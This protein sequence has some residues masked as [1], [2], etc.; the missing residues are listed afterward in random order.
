VATPSPTR[1]HAPERRPPSGGRR[2]QIRVLIDAVQQLS[3]ARTVPEVQAIVRSAARRLTGADGATFVLRQGDRCYYADE[4]AIAPLWKGQRFPLGTCISGWVMLN[5]EPAAI[6]NIYSDDRIPHEAYRPTFVKSLLMVPMRTVDPIGAIGNYWASAHRPTPDEI[7]LLQA[8]ADS[9][10]V[11]MENV[12]VYQELEQRVRDRTAELDQRR[13]EL[14]AANE[15]LVQLDAVRTRF[16][17]ATAHELRSPLT[18]VMGFASV[19]STRLAE[20]EA[21]FAGAIYQAATRLSALVDDLLKVAELEHEELQLQRERVLVSELIG[22]S[23]RAFSVAATEA[24]ITLSSALEEGLAIDVDPLRLAQLLDN[25]ISNAIKYT[26]A[27][28]NVEVRAAAKGEHVAIEVV[29]DGIGIDDVDKPRLFDAFF[30]ALSGREKAG[31]TGLGLRISREIARAHG[32]TLEVA[33]TP[34]GG[35]TFRLLLPR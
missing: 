17:H 4:D 1:T 12:R 8:L 7:E 14:E 20:P 2:E 29:D 34:G 31:G 35:S 5:R 6:E 19:L 9:T 13:R 3:L 16:A 11:A 10:A 21:D 32:G 28:G 26:S 25:L 23:L 18:T 15:Q 30:R 22:A 33:D 24:G 27:G